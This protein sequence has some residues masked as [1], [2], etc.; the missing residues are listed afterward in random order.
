[1]RS[2]RMSAES[3]SVG[4]GQATSVRRSLPHLCRVPWPA[5][6]DRPDTRRRLYGCPVADLDP[7]PM[8]GRRRGGVGRSPGTI[9]GDGDPPCEAFGDNADRSSACLRVSLGAPGLKLRVGVDQPVRTRCATSA[10]VS[11]MMII[12]G[13][14][15]GAGRAGH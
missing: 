4:I 13:R 6:D 5:S 11:A 1:M 3:R 10:D 8:M 14:D 9:S 15:L 7:L 12:W 2:P